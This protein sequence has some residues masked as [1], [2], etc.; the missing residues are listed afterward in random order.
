MRW[1]VKVLST[2]FHGHVYSVYILLQMT[3]RILELEYSI[4]AKVSENGSVLDNITVWLKGK[5]Y[6]QPI[7]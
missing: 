1:D 3:F 5:T 7:E 2:Y 4:Q 6:Q